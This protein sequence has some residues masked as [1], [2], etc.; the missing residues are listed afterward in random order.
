MREQWTAEAAVRRL[1][2]PYPL[3]VNWGP[4]QSDLFPDW[5]SIV[6][7]ATVGPGWSASGRGRWLTGPNGLEGSDAELVD[8]LERVPTGRLVVLGEPGAGKSVLLVRLVLDLLARRSP[9]DPVPLLLPLAGWNPADGLNDWIERRLILEHDALS[10]PVGTLGVGSQAS[11]LIS[12]RRILPI[13]DGFD[14]LSDDA[15]NAA[16]VRIND[17]LQPN[18]RMVLASRTA[19]YRAVVRRPDGAGQPLIGAAAIEISPLKSDVVAHYLQH[20]AGGALVAERWEAVAGSLRTPPTDPLSQVF[21]TPL[22]VSLARSVYSPHPMAETSGEAR[23]PRELL[24]GL[25]FRTRE[26]IE[27]HLFDEFVKAAYRRHP[28]SRRW[29]PWTAEQAQR[30]LAFLARAVQPDATERASNLEW[31]KLRDYAPARLPA[32]VAGVVAGTAFLAAPI[33]GTGTGVGYIAALVTGLV[34]WNWV[35]PGASRLP[36]GL[37]GGLLGGMLGAAAAWLT[38]GD[39]ADRT[40]ADLAGAVIGGGVAIGIVVAPFGDAVVAFAAAFVGSAVLAV[41]EHEPALAGV[42]AAVGLPGLRT[43]NS[44]G[45]A[46][47]VAVAVGLAGRPEPA[48]TARLAPTGLLVGAAAAASVGLLVGAQ[49]GAR[50]GLLV[51]AALVV[52]AGYAGGVMFAEPVSSLAKAASPLSV[53]RRDRGTFWRSLFGVGLALGCGSGV[54]L[55]VSPTNGHTNGLAVGVGLGAA[56]FVASGLAF[57]FMRTAWGSFVLARCWLAVSGS[58]PWRLTA[59]LHYAH[60]HRGVLRQEGAVYQFRHIKL[61][62]RLAGHDRESG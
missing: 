10:R 3:S 33:V 56:I 35:H 1:N 6:T 7:L 31:W 17:A 23:D 22:T 38:L 62:E 41:Y 54:A 50:S 48:R 19:D 28:R 32:F 29:S 30:W 39:L 18:Q 61:Q 26:Q 46:C 59:F 27:A 52:P 24:D 40:G 55:G 13:L 51:G 15:K 43:I 5:S 8:V 20:S 34:M 14:E 36:R 25:R 49:A 21:T 45:V 12:G 37:I 42:R 11:A 57:A 2:D 16:L 47:A 60:V 4:A 44:V 58:V 53:L 9:G